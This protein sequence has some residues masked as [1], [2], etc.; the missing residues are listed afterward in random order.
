MQQN[1]KKNIA[2]EILI[3]TTIL[4]ITLLCWL[5]IYPYNSFKKQQISNAEKQIEIQNVEMDSLRLKLPS[6]KR[7]KLYNLLKSERPDLVGDMGEDEFVNKFADST[8]SAKLYDLMQSEAKDLVGEL[9]QEEFIA[10]CVDDLSENSV[11]SKFKKIES[12]KEF[13]SQKIED[14]QL[15]IFTLDEHKNLFF[16]VLSIL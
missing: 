1:T 4:V 3:L 2:K 7:K 13:L 16:N 11:S 15:K 5:T 10:L 6:E 8:K 9:G 14:Y 12:N